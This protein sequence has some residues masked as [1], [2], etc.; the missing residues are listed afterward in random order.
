MDDDEF[1]RGAVSIQWLERRLPALISAPV[2]ITETRLAAVAGALL[3][4]RD[5]GVS[6]TVESRVTSHE[7]DR[8]RDAARLDALR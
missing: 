3:A 8:W 1:R 7:G 2:P 6:R 4:E 5:R